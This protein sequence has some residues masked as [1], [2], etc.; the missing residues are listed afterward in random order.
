MVEKAGE[1]IYEVVSFKL[2]NELFGLKIESIREILKPLD[3]TPIPN[4]KPYVI[5]VICLRNKIVPIFNFRKIFNIPDSEYTN[6][7]RILV[8]E[9]QEKIIGLM[10]D[11]VRE[12]L[13]IKETDLESPPSGLGDESSEYIRAVAKLE[14]NLLSL[15]DIEKILK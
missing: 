11:E 6:D 8:V 15:L 12:V 7:T 3:V 13:R 14:N 9:L 1:E 4:S 5:G 10:V 2:E